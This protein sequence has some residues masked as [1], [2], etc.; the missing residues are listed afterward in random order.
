MS[1]KDEQALKKLFDYQKFGK[2]ER[3]E[4]IIKETEIRYDAELSDD[5]LSLVNAAGE[6]NPGKV[7][8]DS[9]FGAVGIGSGTQVGGFTGDF[10]G[11]FVKS[12]DSE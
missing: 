2:N 1:G 8:V 5:D 10:V 4:R 3:L 11:N 6:I 7:E 9:G 12:S